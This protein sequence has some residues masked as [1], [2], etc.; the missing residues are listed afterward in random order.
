[1]E[2]RAQI[3]VGPP[4]PNPTTAYWQEPAD[5]IASLRS[6]EDLPNHIDYVIIG[7]GISGAAIAYNLLK[8]QPTSSILMLEARQACSGATGRNGGHT[9]AASYRSFLDHEAEHGLEE[10]IRIARLEYA[11]IIETHALA[12]GFNIDCASTPCDTVDIIY[13]A[14]NLARGKEA[15]ARMQETMGH[16]DPAARYEILSAEEAEARFHTLNALGAF[17]YEA[18]SISAYR[19][20]VGLLKHCLEQGMQL[21]TNTPVQAIQPVKDFDPKSPRWTAKTSRGDVETANLIIATNGYTAHLLPQMQGIIVPLRGQITAQRPGSKL[22]ILVTTYSF[23]YAEGYEYM[24]SRPSSTSDAGTIIIGGGLGRL[25]NAGASEFGTTRDAELNDEISAYLYDCTAGYF[26][27]NWGEDATAG[28]IVKEWSGVMG[29]SSDGLPYVGAMPDMPG[30]FICASFNGH[31][32]VLCLKSGEAL[33]D[34]IVG[35]GYA[36][37]FPKALVVSAERF[38]KK[39]EGRL[40]MRASVPGEALFDDRM[41]RL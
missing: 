34:I 41:E 7:S 17:V 26:G 32:M 21:Q 36:G 31:G 24:I 11:N 29:T 27:D 16:D 40:D 19:F 3:P 2:D 10:A 8:K 4:R 5:E 6:T 20:T 9:K 39:F 30:V 13:D 22:P 28:R 1:M 25:A 18:G 15:I 23:I 33:S 37:W 38:G 12:R 35:G 14:G